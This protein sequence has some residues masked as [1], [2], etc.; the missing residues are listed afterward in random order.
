MRYT[1]TWIYD[2]FIAGKWDQYTLDDM[3]RNYRE[4]LNRA[5]PLTLIAE[6]DGEPVATVSLVEIDDVENVPYTPWLSGFYVQPDYRGRG[7]ARILI[8]CVKD[9]ARVRYADTLYLHTEHADGYYQKLGWTRVEERINRYG[10]AA[11]IY[12]TALLPKE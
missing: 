9:L 6:W 2:E 1:G 8:E 5:F 11:R 7:I 10:E 12:C 4:R 3:C